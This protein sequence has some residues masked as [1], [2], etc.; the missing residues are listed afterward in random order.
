MVVD[1]RERII[2]VL[3]NVISVLSITGSAL[4]LVAAIYGWTQAY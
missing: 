2:D 3:R 4:I 1:T